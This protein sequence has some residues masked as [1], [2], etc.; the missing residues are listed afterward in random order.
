MYDPA[1][2]GVPANS[3]PCG[4]SETGRQSPGREAPGQRRHAAGRGEL[5]RVRNVDSSFR[6]R[7]DARDND[8]R[9]QNLQR[10]CFQRELRYLSTGIERL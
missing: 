7:T 10:K 9:R 8:V 3:P 6:K 5:K 4:K 1:S 2:V